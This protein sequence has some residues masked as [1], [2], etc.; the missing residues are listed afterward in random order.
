MNLIVEKQIWENGSIKQYDI[1]NI[2]QLICAFQNS[3]FYVQLQLS[4]LYTNK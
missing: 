1:V 4:T 3:D 2:W